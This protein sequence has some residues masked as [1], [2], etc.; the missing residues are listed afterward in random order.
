M[1]LHF[2]I[3]HFLVSG[4]FLLTH[5]LLDH[6]KK[7]APSRIINVTA[8]AHQLGVIDFDDINQDNDY[9]PGH[10]YAQSKLAVA[11]FTIELA[12]Q[13]EGKHKWIYSY[14]LNFQHG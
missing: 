4:H 12:K 8:H 10:A 9:N 6:L 2:L 14:F 11:L 1:R 13:L 5:L 3:A 7:S